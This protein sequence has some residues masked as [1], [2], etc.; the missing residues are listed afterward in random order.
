MKIDPRLAVGALVV[1]SAAAG[2]SLR[3]LVD[4]GAPR[5]AAQEPRSPPADAP[6]SASRAASSAP[7]AATGPM[8]SDSMEQV[9]DDIYRNAKW[10][11]NGDGGSTSGSGSLL[12]TTLVYR[13]FLQRF[14]KDNQVRSV[15][16]A[17]CGDW[18]FSSAIDWTGI[19][20]K[21]FDVVPSVI[22]EDKKK[23]EKTNIHFFVADIV[24]SDLPA[25]D[26]LIVKHVLQHLPTTAVQRFLTQLPK[27]R[28]ALIV[29][30]V[31]PT[32][33]S[34]PNWDIAPGAFRYLDVTGP[35]F[36]VQGV[37]VLTYWD[38]THM[39]QTVYVAGRPLWG[40]VE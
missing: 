28:H 34:S 3:A 13:T 35:P 22:A 21:G 1:L 4:R 19:D 24:E 2:W 27:Y 14:L 12:Q 8:T 39:Q 40:S 5:H 30:S 29:D 31:N 20:Y 11:R 17:G 32:T 37:K 23:Y 9:F 25:A 15:V 38:G 26:L 16:D 6:A 36:N 7:D 18:E 10:G 33:L